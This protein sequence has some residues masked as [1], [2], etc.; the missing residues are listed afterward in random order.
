MPVTKAK[1]DEQYTRAMARCGQ[2]KELGKT[3]PE[4]IQI[5]TEEKFYMTVISK[6]FHLSGPQLARSK[7]AEDAK[8]A[9]K[10]FT[11]QKDSK[12][13]VREKEIEDAAWF[14]N[15][16]HDVGKHTFTKMV[17]FVEWSN[18]DM[19]DYE[20]ARTKL[21][22][23]IDSV[24]SLIADSGK[25]QRLEDEKTLLGINMERIQYVF[26]MATKRVE[27][28]KW[29][30]SMLI[31]TMCPTCRLQAMNQMMAASAI[32]VMPEGLVQAEMEEVPQIEQ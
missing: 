10:T 19:N 14:H 4:I 22:K 1:F 5:L 30:N 16:L 27:I 18:E 23:F 6:V 17:Q 3:D 7:I 25:I 28:M 20:K 2:L 26:R 9:D 13:P 21:C 31:R 24:E 8:L 29:Y 12:R 32:K 11:E 15:L